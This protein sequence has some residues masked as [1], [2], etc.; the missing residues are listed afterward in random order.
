MICLAHYIESGSNLRVLHRVL[1]ST[2]FRHSKKKPL[3]PN[4]NNLPSQPEYADFLIAGGENPEADRREA[5]TNIN[6]CVSGRR[7]FVACWKNMPKPTETSKISRIGS[8]HG[9]SVLPSVS[10]DC[11]AMNTNWGPTLIT[12]IYPLWLKGIPSHCR[13]ILWQRHLRIFPRQSETGYP[14]HYI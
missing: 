2:N 6:C 13:D 8:S 3:C 14:I 12:Q 5:C 7:S 1:S 11:L 9:T 4:Q 10:F